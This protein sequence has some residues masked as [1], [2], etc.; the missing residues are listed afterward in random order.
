MPLCCNSWLWRGY[1]AHVLFT[2]MVRWCDGGEPR[3][4]MIDSAHICMRPDRH[5]SETYML[6]TSDCVSVRRNNASEMTVGFAHQDIIPH[7][8]VAFLRLAGTHSLTSTH[9]R[10]VFVVLCMITTAMQLALNYVHNPHVRDR[11]TT[12]QC[13][14]YTDTN[15]HTHTHSLAAVDISE[16]V[17][18]IP[19]FSK[20]HTGAHAYLTHPH[21]TYHVC[22]CV[23]VL[24]F[25]RH[26]RTLCVCVCVAVAYAGLSGSGLHLLHSRNQKCVSS[27]LLLSVVFCRLWHISEDVI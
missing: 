10:V 20:Q 6:C 13:R 2:H 5:V 3:P 24:C 14:T 15:A 1:F 26:A 12:V 19:A 16:Q 17:V 7:V 8:H 22:A 21:Q 4:G 25:A 18:I 11:Q 27:R 9:A 23:C